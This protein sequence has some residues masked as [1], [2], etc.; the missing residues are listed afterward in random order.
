[1]AVVAVAIS[2]LIIVR[3]TADGP[4]DVVRA[5]LEAAR[6]GDPA[7][8]VRAGGL[9]IPPAGSA[10]ALA[11]VPWTVRS[12]G[13]PI[14][15]SGDDAEV[16][17]AI[18]DGSVV[19]EGRF[20]LHRSGGRWH[21]IN[22]Y[23]TVDVDPS[24][25]RFAPGSVGKQELLPG[26]YTQPGVA[27][28]LVHGTDAAHLVAL[29]PVFADGLH[30]QPQFAPT[31]TAQQRFQQL[32]DAYLDRCRT[33]PGCAPRPADTIVRAA[34]GDVFGA[35]LRETAWRVVRYPAV[36]LPGAIDRSTDSAPAF[37]GQVT[38]PG[39]L[40]V[41]GVTATGKT[42]SA[43]CLLSGARYTLSAWV[44]AAGALQA[45]WTGTSPGIPVDCGSWA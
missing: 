1:M 9:V 18:T 27:A 39:V 7:A 11:R 5:Y 43:T 24:P 37:T 33:D 4:D 38:V 3:V 2:T 15:D 26:V 30:V 16:Q 14:N 41:D 45:G 32:S 22:P 42:F 13:E 12:V 17:A 10:A 29:P 8:A 36:N 28:E 44:D 25:V 19:G 23:V 20:A 40:H 21:I 6:G 35:G 31:A 34:G